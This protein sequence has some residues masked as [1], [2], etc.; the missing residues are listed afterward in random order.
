MNRC[1]VELGLTERTD[2]TA[3]ALLLPI[4][5]TMITLFDVST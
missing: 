2:T 1:E 3:E 5:D 4:A